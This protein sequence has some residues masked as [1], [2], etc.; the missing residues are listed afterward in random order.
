MPQRVDILIL[1]VQWSQGKHVVITSFETNIKIPKNIWKHHRLSFQ[2]GRKSQHRT[3]F[4]HL[5]FPS[6]SS[7]THTRGSYSQMQQR[8]GRRA[9]PLNS[10][11]I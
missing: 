4:R 10:P 5:R 3:E 7:C 8:Y 11:A 1:S 9:V 2:F 6:P